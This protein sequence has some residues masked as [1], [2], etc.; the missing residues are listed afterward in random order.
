M[1]ILFPRYYLFYI[2][3]FGIFYRNSYFY[4]ESPV[5]FYVKN[6]LSE[7]RIKWKYYFEDIVHFICSIRYWYWMII[8]I[9]TRFASS[10]II[11]LFRVR[12]HYGLLEKQC[13]GF[14]HKI[15]CCKWM[16][17]ERERELSF[18]GSLRIA[19]KLQWSNGINLR[20]CSLQ[21]NPT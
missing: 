12:L 20:L 14:I 13:P 8:K 11:S 3:M 6:D 2:N 15:Y 9:R 17:E 19:Y 21:D 4:W 10:V 1:K 5:C 18:I 16:E 7:L